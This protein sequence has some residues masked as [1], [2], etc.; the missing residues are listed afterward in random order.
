VNFALLVGIH[1]DFSGRTEGKVCLDAIGTDAKLDPR[2]QNTRPVSMFLIVASL[3]FDGLRRKIDHRHA[4]EAYDCQKKKCLFQAALNRSKYALLHHCKV[5][6]LKIKNW[7]AGAIKLPFRNL[8]SILCDRA[9]R[10]END[11]LPYRLF[12]FHERI[13]K[14][15]FN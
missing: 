9:S 14:K 13:N 5:S 7:L 4:S 15:I 11:H 1:F 10:V 8:N 6:R 12:Y 3:L 2:E